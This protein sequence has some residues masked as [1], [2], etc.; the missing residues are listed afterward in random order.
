VIVVGSAVSL[1]YYLRVVAAVWMRPATELV[2]ATPGAISPATG[3]PAL[4]GGSAEADVVAA[5]A[6][7][8][9]NWEVELVA[10]VF[11]VATIALGI[12]P[13]PL[14]DLARDAAGSLTGLL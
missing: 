9:R 11:G 7:P 4:A 12:V 5:E 8:G 13:Q 10:V 1:A 6:I 3:R 14:F 2:A